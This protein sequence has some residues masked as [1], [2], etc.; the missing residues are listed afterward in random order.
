MLHQQ[1]KQVESAEGRLMVTWESSIL[2]CSYLTVRCEEVHVNAKNH[3]P[4]QIHLYHVFLTVKYMALR[5]RLEIRS[6]EVTASKL[7]GKLVAE[8]QFH[9]CAI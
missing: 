9:R 1:F 5:V 3:L 6:M 4:R 8:V 7:V 2:N